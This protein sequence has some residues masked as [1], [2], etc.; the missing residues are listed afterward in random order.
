[1]L[2]GDARSYGTCWWMGVTIPI[3]YWCES[4]VFVGLS[5]TWF[6]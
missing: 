2:I 5:V 3:Y 4:E 6:V 1:M